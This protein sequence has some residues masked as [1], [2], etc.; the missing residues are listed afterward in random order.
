MAVNWLRRR[1]REELR[2]LTVIAVFAASSMLSIAYYPD[3][4]H[5]AFI[6][7]V[8]FVAIAET[9]EWALAVGGHRVAT[10]AGP[11]VA[12]AAIVGVVWQLQ[13]TMTRSWH[14]YPVSQDTRFGRIDFVDRTD[15]PVIDT[16]RTL[17]EQSSNKD[18]FCY[19]SIAGPYLM[20]GGR[21]PTPYQF[22]TP[23]YNNAEQGDD[24]LSI[25]ET[26]QVPLV[27]TAPLLAGADDPVVEYV[28]QHYDFVRTGTWTHIWLYT[29][30]STPSAPGG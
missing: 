12:L 1:D 2:T 28:A 10:A 21:N 22:F 7:P 25:L 8:F 11:L 19:P 16:A 23:R 20:T 15:L 3:L 26:R 6:A 18:L 17:V 9:T 5:I 30:K 14:E 24:I 29:R 27:I 13:R 4:I